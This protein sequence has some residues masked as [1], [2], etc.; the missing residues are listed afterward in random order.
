M[1]RP[2]YAI[3]G[4]LMVALGVIGLVLPVM[5]TTVFMILAAWLFA[6]SSPRFEAWLLAHP[7]FGPPIVQWRQNGAIPPLAKGFAAISMVGG[8]GV[9]WFVVRPAPWL[10]GAV[11]VALLASAAFVLSRPS[12]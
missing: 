7:I 3:A 8:F 6:R 4:W 11:A 5:P 10:A 2:L 9:F 12:H 1:K